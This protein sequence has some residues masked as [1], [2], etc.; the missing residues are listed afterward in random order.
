MFTLARLMPVTLLSRM[1]LLTALLALSFILNAG[2][3]LAQTS[4]DHGNSFNTATALTL[5]TAVDGVI[6]PADDRDVF[7]FEVPD[8]VEAIDVW[9]YTQGSFEDTAGAIFDPT[10]IPI[11]TNDDNPLSTTTSHFYTGASLTPGTYFVLVVGN[12]EDT[13]S[14]SLHTRTGEDQGDTREESASLDVGSSA[15]GIIGSA[16]DSDLFKVEISSRSDIV[17]Y[18]SGAADTVGVLYDYRGVEL[19]RNNDSSMSEHE[20][21]FFIGNSLEP[22]VYYIEVLAFEIGPYR[23]HVEQVD[24]QDASR[25]QATELALESSELGFINHRNDE[26]YFELTVPD[27][28]DVWVYAVGPTD[29]IGELQDSNGSRIAYNDDSDLSVGRYS[30]FLAKNLQ[31]GTHYLKVSGWAGD[32]GPY[33][34]FAQEAPDAG[35]TMATAE[36]LDL[37]VPQIGL[38]DPSTDTDLYEL[39]LTQATEVVVYTTGDVDTTGELLSSDG[40]TLASL[41]TDDDSGTGLNFSMRH[42]LAPGTYYVR[43]GS[44]ESETGAYAV[45]AE[46]VSQLRVDGPGLARRIAEGFDEEF[47]RLD[48]DYAMDTWIYG[49]GSMDT[50]GTLYDS[51]FNVIALNDDSF[52]NGRFSAFHLRESLGAGTYY[53]NV[54]SF[55]TGTGRFGV[56]VETIPEHGD[57]LDTATPLT[58]GPRVPGRIVADGDTDYFRLDLQEKTNVFLYARTSTWTSLKLDVLDSD[59]E[60]ISVNIVPLTSGPFDVD[61]FLVRDDFDAGTYYVR[62][63]VE[64]SADYTVHALP[65]SSYDR[66]IRG[67][68]AVTGDPLYECQWHLH[69]LEDED[70]DINVEPVWASGINGAGIN[71]AVVDDGLDHYHEDL[72]PNVATYL[73]HDYT[74][75]G[76]VHTPTDSHGTAVAGVIAARDNNIGARG[77]AP[78]ATIY[79]YNFLLFQSSL[80][81]MDALSRNRDITAVHNNSW[82]PIGGPGLSPGLRSWDLAIEASVEKGY[83]GRGTFYV[84]SAGNGGDEGDDSNLSETKNFYA[85]TSVCAVE[86]SGVRSFYSETG[87]NLWVCAPSSAGSRAIVTT[88]NSD[89]YT[90]RFGGTSASAPQVSGVAALLRQANPELTWRDL[91]LIMAATARKNDEENTGWEDGALQYGSSTERYHFNHEYGFG[92]VD[93]GAAVDLAR[94]WV[95]VPA[96]ETSE[97]SSGDLDALVPDATSLDDTTTV[98]R[99][100]TL[101]TDVDFV[102]YVDIEVN[103]SHP[104]F[105]DLEI[106]L[107]SP[108]G[109]VSTLVGSFESEELVPLIGE[110]RFGSAKHLGEDPNGQW[111]LRI[112]DEIPGLEGTLESWTLKVYGHRSAPTPP[113]VDTITPGSGSLTVSWSA[114]SFM[115]GAAITSYDL[116]YIPTAA[117]E[118]DESS[119]NVVESV[120]SSG[121]GA[122]TA[123]ITG[124]VGG[125]E[126]DVQVRGVNSSGPGAW[127][128]SASG[129]PAVSTATCS[130]GGAIGSPATNPELVADCDTLLA[131][132]DTLAG[133]GLLNWSAGL[134]IGGWDGVTEGTSGDGTRR[135]TEIELSGRS[136]SGQIPASL[137]DLVGLETLDLS[138]N[139]L[140]GSIPVELSTLPNLEALYLSGNQLTACITQELG[141]IPQNDFGSPDLPSCVVL[142]SGLTIDRTVLTPE[143]DPN[144]A[145]YTAVAEIS[146]VTVTPANDHGATFQIL[147]GS[148]AAIA[149]ADSDRDGHQ[150]VLTIGENTVKVRVDSQDQTAHHVYTIV[151]TLAD[152]VSRYDRNG[153]GSIDGTEV[154]A[155][156]SDYF[157]NLI[158]GDE[159]LAVISAYF[160]N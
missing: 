152:A 44:Y 154:L 30:F 63:T 33:R 62:I 17:M 93:A 109:Q 65:Y 28:T 135:V 82:G 49:Y 47:Y 35:D 71:V 68:Q 160:R 151:V 121:D 136:L 129:T 12:G 91:K 119:W 83:G 122:L 81:G 78:R 11:A 15:E 140:T 107:E 132:R 103:F 97:V 118:T 73:N 64:S 141:A 23:L 21:E 138:N 157:G 116:R 126:Y 40:S 31:A 148:D 48:L 89:R 127:S 124:L 42:D 159:A 4:D 38:I 25:S 98:S 77:V 156:V 117:D 19:A 95:N 76:D 80:T 75:G 10:G 29:T 108:S 1:G 94:D 158:S 34:V 67:C 55:G 14:Y 57:S 131:A 36:A 102:E 120:W 37:G 51:D 155:A 106:E 43:V 18:T 153:D 20:Y 7:T 145:A 2:E 105:R 96:M 8:S 74:G 45:F 125:R 146:R 60:E 41:S 87:A 53:V 54:R 79:G 50:V 46:P 88:D 143:F 99:D 56:A 61:G 110:F 123:E 114:P 84:W 101:T 104:S 137:G 26:D 69:N 22:G 115:R 3:S 150:V 9:V 70:E 16:T 113:S 32:R 6:D 24:D 90:N 144:Q 147:D 128:A 111:T 72:S 58:L 130:D 86:D 39:N 142:L 5:G 59:G 139:D 133:D 13:G 52:L 66:F 100:L 85:M 134:D 112:T 149:D 27:A 92:M